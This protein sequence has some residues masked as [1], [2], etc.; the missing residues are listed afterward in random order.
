MSSQIPMLL[1]KSEILI[2]VRFHSSTRVCQATV[3][4]NRSNCMKCIYKDYVSIEIPILAQRYML[5][6]ALLCYQKCL[7]NENANFS[8]CCIA[9]YLHGTLMH[10]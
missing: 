9:G 4:E 3:D 5:I 7:L 2:T 6:D 10:L 1:H 8:A